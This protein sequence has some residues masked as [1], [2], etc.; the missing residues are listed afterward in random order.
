MAAGN[1]GK[2]HPYP[3]AHTLR[4]FAPEFMSEQIKSDPLHLGFLTAI[5]VPECGFIGGLLVTNRFGRPLEFQCTAP[6]KPNR[7]QSILYGSTLVPFVVGELIGRTLV[8]KLTITPHLIL[9][10]YPEM[11]EVRGHVSIPVVCL[12]TE[13]IVISSPQDS[14]TDANQPQPAESECTARVP[15]G[16][17]FGR[18]FL[19]FHAD[20]SGDGTVVHEHARRIPPDADL[21]EP[22]ERVREALKETVHT[23]AAR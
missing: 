10:D 19:R 9:T 17:T 23:G 8:D 5:E 7:T 1:D 18:Q 6:V 14:A 22:L 15:G 4:R 13:N 21:R 2:P 16:M 12:D 20:H 3:A 11:L